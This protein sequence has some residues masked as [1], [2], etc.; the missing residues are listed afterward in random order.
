MLEKLQIQCRAN[1]VVLVENNPTPIVA[2]LYGVQDIVGV[3]GAVTMGVD[4]A[5]LG[6]TSRVWQRI[7]RVLWRNSMVARDGQHGFRRRCRKSRTCEK[8]FKN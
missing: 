6:T 7:E 1:G 4:P 8:Q 3:V 5:F 2:L